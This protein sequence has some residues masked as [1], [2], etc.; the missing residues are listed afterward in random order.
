MKDQPC[1]PL[2]HKDL[3]GNEVNVLTTEL[4][5]KIDLLPED[6]ET[7]ERKAKTENG[8]L[9]KLLGLQSSVTRLEQWRATK[10]PK[11]RSDL[12]NFEQRLASTQENLRTNEKDIEEPRAKVAICSTMIGDMS[13]LDDALKDVERSE[14]DLETKRLQ[15]SEYPSD[16]N[17]AA[18]KDQRIAKRSELD[19]LKEMAKSKQKKL[20]DFLDKTRKV[21]EAETQA[22]NEE[23]RLKG[24]LQDFEAIKNRGRELQQKLDEVETNKEKLRETLSPVKH[25]LDLLK[26]RQN[27]LKESNARKTQAFKQQF[28]SIQKTYDDM[29]RVTNELRKLAQLNL[30]DEIER[31]GKGLADL[32]KVK[33]DEVT[34]CLSFD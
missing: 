8:K 7:A 9:E 30:A 34:F 15:L 18:L 10:L 16:L 3:N 28:D 29:E 24:L 14:K 12:A 27:D 19:R 6:I 32:R 1:C 22:R 11:L 25:K 4:N 13:I 23:L 33:T 2:C 21:M 5:D 26:Q 31:V 20:D 17:V